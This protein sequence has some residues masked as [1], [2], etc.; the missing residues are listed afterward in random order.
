VLEDQSFTF[1]V[2]AIDALDKKMTNAGINA[3]FRFIVIKL[4][5]ER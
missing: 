1:D 3:C 5:I 4:E 2:C